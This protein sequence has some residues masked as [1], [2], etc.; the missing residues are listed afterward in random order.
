[1]SL[2]RVSKLSALC[3]A[4]IGATMAL[5][6]C[7][8]AQ[9]ADGPGIYAL[10]MP[11]EGGGSVDYT[12]VIPEG[13]APGTPV[14]LVLGL[15]FGGPPQGA[16]RAVTEILIEPGLRELGAIIVAPDSLE[17]NWS[18]PENERAVTALLD[19]I[20]ANY[21]IDDTRTLVT[22][23]SMGGTGSWHFGLTFPERFKAVV[24]IASRPPALDGWM[25]PVLAIHS[26]ADEVA[27]FAPAEA[28]ITELQGRGVNARLIA[29]DTITH[30]QTYAFADSLRQ[31]IPWIHEVWGAP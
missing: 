10:N 17:G 27:V 28:A 18:T 20:E 16:G 15:H 29:L 8:E 11:L 22:G 1:M 26:R 7:A 14:P 6:S 25:L 5:V 30:Y 23:F 24:P 3:A 13:Y 12:L 31:T 19:M 2:E 9:P 21:A 4:T